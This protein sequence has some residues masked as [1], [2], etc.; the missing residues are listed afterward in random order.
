MEGIAAAKAKGVYAG[1][2]RTPTI[3][4]DAIRRVH[5]DEK[6]A[7]TAIAKQLKVSRSSVYR[8]LAAG[9]AA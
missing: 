2:G 1:K 6:L 7:P 3:D 9:A 5:A 4:G 8:A